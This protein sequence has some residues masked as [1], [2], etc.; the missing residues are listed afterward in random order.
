MLFGTAP[1]GVASTEKV[2]W[3]LRGAV[4]LTN[5]DFVKYQDA[6]DRQKHCSERVGRRRLDQNGVLKR[7]LQKN[8]VLEASRKR[9]L[10]ENS[11][12][13]C[14]RRRWLDKNSVLEGSRTRWIDKN[15]VL[16]DPEKWSV[17]VRPP[18]RAHSSCRGTTPRRVQAYNI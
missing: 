6:L 8:S 13:A 17:W 18:W 14:S 1:E 11:V 5:I 4:G 7:R 2:L 12:L 16:E 3:K 15:I 9:W 10:D